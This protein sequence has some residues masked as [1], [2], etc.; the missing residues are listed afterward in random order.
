M[1]D[2]S[3]LEIPLRKSLTSDMMY[4]LKPSAP[5]SRS[6][7]LSLAPLN[8]SV[9]TS[10]DQIIF[11]APTGR[12]GTYLDQTQSY[13]KFGVQVSST[14]AS[15]QGGSGVYLDNTAY[16]FSKDKIFITRLIYLKHKMR[17]D[18]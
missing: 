6:Y 9:Y 14:A 17:L 16:S 13:L 10:N 8:K 3:G 18:N 5:K 12:K 15:G 1:T 7:R 11:E 4:G 2:T